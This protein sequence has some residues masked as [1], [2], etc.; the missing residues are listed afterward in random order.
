M[1][2]ALATAGIDHVING[3]RMAPWRDSV[4]ASD[5]DWSDSPFSQQY[6]QKVRTQGRELLNAEVQALRMHVQQVRT[7]RSVAETLTAEVVDGPKNEIGQWLATLGGNSGAASTKSASWIEKALDQGLIVESGQ[8]WPPQR[9][10]S[11]ETPDV[12]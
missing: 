3:D 4:G 8:I 12:T 5:E 2:A 9:P 7:V 10:C 6:V 1:L 11:P